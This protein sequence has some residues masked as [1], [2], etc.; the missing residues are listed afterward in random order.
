MAK[1]EVDAEF[2]QILTGEQAR[3]FGYLVTLL[4]DVHEANNVL[5]Q[6]NLVLWEKAREFEKGTSFTAW[7]RKIAYFQTLAFLRDSK[8]DKHVFSEKLMGQLTELPTEEA[9]D[10][11]R[12]ALRHCLSRLPEKQR[13]LLRERY[14]ADYTSISTLA[15]QKG[16]TESAVKM[17]LLRARQALKMC[18]KRQLVVEP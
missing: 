3:L 15:S 2:A 7:S 17:A 4:G 16:A 18:I 6:T 9:P 5:Q 14:G 8:R 12:L 11:R 10:E 13:Q 1:Y